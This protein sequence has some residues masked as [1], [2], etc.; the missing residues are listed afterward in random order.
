ML[1]IPPPGLNTKNSFFYWLKVSPYD[2]TF[3]IQ[4]LYYFNNKKTRQLFE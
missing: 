2:D 4:I 1:M 3:S